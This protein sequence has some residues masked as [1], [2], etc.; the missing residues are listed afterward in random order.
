MSK[1]TINDRTRIEPGQSGPKDCELLIVAGDRLQQTHLR[2]SDMFLLSQT[3]YDSM[4]LASC[5]QE[6]KIV[7]QGK[8]SIVRYVAGQRRG[9]FSVI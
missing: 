3:C 2:P 4:G 8:V 6:R 5:I 1:L 9:S 7:L